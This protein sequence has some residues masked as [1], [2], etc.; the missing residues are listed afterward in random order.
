VDGFQRRHAVLALPYAVFR[1]F[2][3]DQAGNLAALI[4]YYAFWSVFPLLLAATT[5]LG[6]VLGGDPA[7]E[8][9]VFSTVLGQFPIIGEHNATRP[10]TGNAVGLIVGLALAIWSG[11][12]VAGMAQ[13]AFNTVYGV[14]R[15]HWPG[16]AKRL[17]RSS[18]CWWWPA[19]GWW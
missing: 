4:A 17:P 1:K 11:L 6:Y 19:P 15:A 16:L 9:K 2:A 8:Q 5:I 18:R 12:G 7:L 3:D 13:Q 10:L 14:S